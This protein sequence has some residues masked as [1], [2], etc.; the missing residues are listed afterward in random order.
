MARSPPAWC[1][2]LAFLLRC[3]C[4]C[5]VFAEIFGVCVACLMFLF[6]I[7]CTWFYYWFSTQ[8]TSRCVLHLFFDRLWFAM[9]YAQFSDRF[10][11]HGCCLVVSEAI[12][13]FLWFSSRATTSC[14]MHCSFRVSVFNV[15]GPVFSI[16][17]A[18]RTP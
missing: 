6:L 17:L 15:I 7:Q 2:L 18:V 5:G 13:V 9:M 3:A 4:F 16:V 10:C 11:M 8:A 14:Y 1:V 12:S